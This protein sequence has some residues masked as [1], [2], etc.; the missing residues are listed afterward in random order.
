MTHQKKVNL[1]RV[2]ASLNT[3]CTECGYSILSAELRRIDFERMKCPKCGAVFTPKRLHSEQNR[4]R[5]Y[6]HEIVI[7]QRS[8]TNLG[9]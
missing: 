1:Q 9:L 5:L 3:V 2:L 6:T 7:A 8:H 4:A